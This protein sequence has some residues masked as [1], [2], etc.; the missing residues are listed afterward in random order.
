MFQVAAETLARLDWPDLVARLA[1]CARTPGGRARA[2][3][4]LFE[5]EPA[6]MRERLAE[7]S[8][9]RALLDGA[10]LPP[11]DGVHDLDGALLRLA[12]GGA[13]TAPELLAIASTLGAL[14]AT[15][16]F[17]AARADAAPRL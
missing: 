15:A 14:R 8:E 11:L 5:A 7:T 10:A 4:P 9:A 6:G 2:E 13:L 12:K 1:A 3:G 16:R 17:L